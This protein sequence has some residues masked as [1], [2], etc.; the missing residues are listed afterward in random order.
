MRI[1]AAGLFSIFNIPEQHA[2]RN[3]SEVGTWARDF[4]VIPYLESRLSKYTVWKNGE[5]L[6]SSF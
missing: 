3:R 1:F 4:S 2:Y 5:A 6:F